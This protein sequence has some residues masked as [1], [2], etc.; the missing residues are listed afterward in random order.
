MFVD[1]PLMNVYYRVMGA[2]VGKNCNIGT[3]VSAPRSI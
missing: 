2:K 3:P 1:T